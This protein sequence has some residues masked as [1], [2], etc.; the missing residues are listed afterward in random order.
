[1]DK[2]LDQLGYDSEDLDDYIR[3]VGK[4]CFLW[5]RVAKG[6]DMQKRF[7]VLPLCKVCDVTYTEKPEVSLRV[8]ADERVMY[9]YYDSKVLAQKVFDVLTNAVA[10]YQKSLNK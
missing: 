1:M 2:L 4:Q 6:E 7:L 10:K 3:V 9:M 8:E 5:C